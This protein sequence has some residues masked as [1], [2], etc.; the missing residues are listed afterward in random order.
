MPRFKI[1]L[2]ANK[3]SIPLDRYA[4][5]WVAF[6]NGKVVALEKT[7]ETGEKT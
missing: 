7:Q 1:S 2:K 6:A 4:G 3:K 5:E